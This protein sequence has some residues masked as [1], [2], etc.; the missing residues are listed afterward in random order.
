MWQKHSAVASIL[1]SMSAQQRLE[2]P[3]AQLRLFK[4]SRCNHHCCSFFLV[5]VTKFLLGSSR[6]VALS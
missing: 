5:L 1:A 6:L 3:F 4:E 2:G